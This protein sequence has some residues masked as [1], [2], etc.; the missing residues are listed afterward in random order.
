MAIA[1]A[2]E[3][4]FLSAVDCDGRRRVSASSV[5]LFIQRYVPLSKIANSLGSLAQHL[6]R[7]CNHL[8]IPVVL[9][10][11]SNNT[12][13]QPIIARESEGYLIKSWKAKHEANAQK[14]VQLQQK[15]HEV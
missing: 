15:T 10:A 1:D 3:K 9:F 12:G 6:W 5:V 8:E 4:G 7:M 14:W 13:N 2:I 11:R